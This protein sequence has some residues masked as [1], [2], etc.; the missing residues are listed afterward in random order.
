MDYNIPVGLQYSYVG[1]IMIRP[2]GPNNI[3]VTYDVPN[4]FSLLHILYGRFQG[5]VKTR[6]MRV[7]EKKLTFIRRSV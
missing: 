7:V 4:G 5:Y 6:T 2:F 3:N 1:Q